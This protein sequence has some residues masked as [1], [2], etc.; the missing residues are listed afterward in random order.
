VIV[1]PQHAPSRSSPPAEPAPGPASSA[2]PPAPA[3]GPRPAS[4]PTTHETSS[5][6]ASS[7]A[8]A[9]RVDPRE[10]SPYP[11]LAVTP[12]EGR[13]VSSPSPDARTADGYL[14]LTARILLDAERTGF[15]TLGV[16][17]ATYGEGKTAAAVNLAVCL[18]RAKGRRGRVLLVD[19]D[20]RTRA[21]TNMFCAKEAPG[22]AAGTS[23]SRHPMLVGTA[24]DGVDLMTAPPAGDELSIAAPSAWIETF[25]ELGAL[26]PHVVV[27]CPAVSEN[28][29]GLVLRECVERIVLVVR[30]GRTTRRVVE[31]TLGE[32]SGNVLGVILNGGERGGDR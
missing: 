19:G 24:L 12:D 31:R 22:A 7:S 27:D 13:L 29:E 16:L 17:S 18:G 26:Y 9:L 6:H 3:E 1:E 15:R 4:D 32:A 2:P 28:P 11:L 10:R 8:L 21:L 14:R 30:A 5:A 25:R 20:S 23:S